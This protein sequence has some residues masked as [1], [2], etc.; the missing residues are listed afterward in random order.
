MTIPSHTQGAC[1]IAVMAK[2]PRSGFSKTR[3][4]PPLT[5]PQAAAMSAAFL[6]DTTENIALAARAA[7]IDGY[8]AYAPA[9]LEALFDGHVAPGTPLLL[10]DGDAA[11][12]GSVRGF[13]RCLLHAITV[14]LDRGYTSVCVLNSDGPTLPTGILVR[15]AALLAE[16]GDRAVFG[17]AEDGGYYILGLKAAH[18]ALFE[19]IDWSTERVAAQTRAR[20]ASIEL[21]MVDLPPWYDID[22]HAALARLLD[23][24]TR[25]GPDAYHAPATWACIDRLGLRRAS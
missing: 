23:G 14:L 16:P 4:V 17:P 15:A 21:P 19:D 18:A 24:P 2:A 10:A 11:M 9:G 1:A 7:A 12:P 8:V 13:G 25:A 20:A 22:D 3:L 5:A 6:R